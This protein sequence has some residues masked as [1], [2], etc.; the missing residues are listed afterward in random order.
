MNKGDRRYS[1]AQPCFIQALDILERRLGV[2][3][4]N[5]LIVRENL[6]DLH[7]FL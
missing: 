4:P 1:E 6:A 5:T 3:H 7:D 2:N